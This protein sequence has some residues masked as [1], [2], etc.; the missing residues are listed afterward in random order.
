MTNEITSVSPSLPSQRLSRD[1]ASQSVASSTQRSDR[2]TQ[3]NESVS[4]TSQRDSNQSLAPKTVQKND[5]RRQL[6]D[7]GARLAQELR[8]TEAERDKLIAERDQPTQQTENN[9]S[10]QEALQRVRESARTR[11]GKGNEDAGPLVEDSYFVNTASTPEG[12]TI[13]ALERQAAL[14]KVKLDDIETQF[15]QTQN[16]LLTTDAKPIE[17]PEAAQK[18]G[19][20]IQQ[21]I[22]AEPIVNISTLTAKDG[23]DVLAIL[24]F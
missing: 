18:I 6:V 10:A 24:S 17:T 13:S 5:E 2:S 9:E 1:D 22:A 11:I 16:S 14:T 21:D 15:K 20:A 12:S 8:K 23:T 4:T 3:V 7:E 19:Q